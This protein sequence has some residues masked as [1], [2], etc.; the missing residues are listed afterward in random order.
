[1]KMARNLDLQVCKRSSTSER[2]SDASFVAT[3]QSLQ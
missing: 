2:I 1:M 3:C